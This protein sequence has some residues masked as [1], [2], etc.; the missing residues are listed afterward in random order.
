LSLALL[1]RL[2]W[3]ILLGSLAIRLGSGLVALPS[4]APPAVALILSLWPLPLRRLSLG[5]GQV[6][7]CCHACTSWCFL[8][9]DGSGFRRGAAAFAIK[10]CR[11]IVNFHRG[12]DGQHRCIVLPGRDQTARR[13]DLQIAMETNALK[14]S[15]KTTDVVIQPRF[16]PAT[17]SCLCGRPR[18]AS[19]ESCLTLENRSEPLFLRLASAA[20][21]DKDD[22]TPKRV[23]WQVGLGPKLLKW[24]KTARGYPKENGSA[25]RLDMCRYV[26]SGNGIAP[27]LPSYR[28]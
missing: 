28:E 1:T 11:R 6:L 2:G 19:V 8:R 9:C 27:R 13:T 17:H 23:G 22:G 25:D 3:L 21:I 18:G 26:V 24:Y 5:L 16:Q 15:T 20:S 12:A 7:F 14:P 4:T 10:Q